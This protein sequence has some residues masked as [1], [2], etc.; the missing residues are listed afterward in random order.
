MAEHRELALDGSVGPTSRSYW[1]VEGRLAAGAYPGKK[2]REELDQ[3]PEVT[4][5]VLEAGIDT[6]V[7]LTQDCTIE[8][9]S[10]YDADVGQEATVERFPIVD[11]SIPTVSL[12]VEVLDFIDDCLKHGRNPYVHCWGGLGRTGTVVGC[13]LIRHGYTDFWNVRDELG[14]LRVGDLEAGHRESPQVPEQWEFVRSWKE[15]R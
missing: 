1:V 15:G 2:G 9:L 13:W 11:N 6:F 7:N 12:M 14:R 5:K 8:D 3:I 4:V 10:H